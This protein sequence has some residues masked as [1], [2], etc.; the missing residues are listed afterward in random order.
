MDG[1][2]SQYSSAPS[3]SSVAAATSVAPVS[4]QKS[5]TVE[6]VRLPRQRRLRLAITRLVAVCAVI[7]TIRYFYWRALS[8]MNP[9]A[10]VFFYCFLVAEVL[11]FL[12][13]VLF[14]FI[15]S[16]PTHYVSLPPLPGRSVD[17]FIPTYNE[18]VEI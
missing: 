9:A 11:S 16:N 2:S 8:T 17:V 7:F 13:S 14:Y 12:E 18:P 5:Q 3:V 6:S 15:A 1:K 10:R 4:I